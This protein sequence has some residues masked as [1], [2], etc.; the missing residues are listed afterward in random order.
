MEYFPLF[1]NFKLR[2][3]NFYSVKTFEKS[4][5]ISNLTNKKGLACTIE[6]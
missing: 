4:S 3:R 2:T 6:L 1:L 5:N